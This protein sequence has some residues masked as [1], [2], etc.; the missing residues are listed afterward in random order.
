MPMMQYKAVDERGKTS[1]GQIEAAN[2]A[3]LEARLG[4]MG[5]DLVN[6]QELQAK[7]VRV[8]AGQYQTS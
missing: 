1:S 8:R 3:D 7:S 5:M 4:R 2:V 6:F